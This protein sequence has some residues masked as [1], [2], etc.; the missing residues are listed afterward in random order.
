[1]WGVFAFVLCSMHVC[2][3]ETNQ[4]IAIRHAQNGEF[5]K[6]MPFF[7]K[8]YDESVA[9]NDT[10]RIVQAARLLGNGFS[11]LK[12]SLNGHRY[13][14]IA[15]EYARDF[16]DDYVYFISLSGLTYYYVSNDQPKKALKYSLIAVELIENGNNA[17]I[18]S[19]TLNKGTTYINLG[20]AYGR[21]GNNQKALDSYLKAASYYEQFETPV[22]ELATLYCNI[23]NCYEEFNQK[24]K[25]LKFFNSGL[26]IAVESNQLPF[27]RYALNELFNLHKA[28]G[29]TE[30][31]LEYLE[32]IHGAE[33]YHA[34]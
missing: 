12:D 5:D 19:D 3:Q 7:L 30:M 24:D 31:A 21:L 16:G 4:D 13:Y 18:A 27:I 23:G 34:K 1:M 32:K 9:V 6:A 15:E 11:L 8:D 17:E 22:P 10:F 20:A 29:N 14:K 25:A 26:T 2:A 33:G 28:A